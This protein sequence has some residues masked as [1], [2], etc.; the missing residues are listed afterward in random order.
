MSPSVVLLL[1]KD[2]PIFV[3][4]DDISTIAAIGAFGHL[5]APIIIQPMIEKLGRKSALFYGCLPLV[6]CW[7]LKYFAINIWVN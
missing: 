5:I 1:A 3:D 2:S 7:I 6:F 4:H